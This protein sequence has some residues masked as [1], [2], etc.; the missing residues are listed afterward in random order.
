M[1]WGPTCDLSGPKY[2]VLG[3]KMAF[4]GLFW[5]KNA[6]LLVMAALEPLI[7]CSK[8]CKTRFP[9]SSNLKIGY[10]ALQVTTQAP[11]TLL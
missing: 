5:P 3:Q 10:A 7:I 8:P 4:C 1:V 2:I 6:F 11:E 9:E